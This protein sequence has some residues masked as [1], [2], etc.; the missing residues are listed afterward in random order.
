MKTE[1]FGAFKL[2][3]NTIKS[4]LI[5]NSYRQPLMEPARGALVIYLLETL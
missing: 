4:T 5:C 2:T 3:R 1:F